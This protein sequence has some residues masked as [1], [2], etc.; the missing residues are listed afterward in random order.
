MPPHDRTTDEHGFGRVYAAH[1]EAVYGFLARRVGAQMA[2]ELTAQTFAEALDHLDRF[3]EGR[4]TH[5]AWLF[6]IAANLLRRHYRHEERSLRAIAAAA[7]S[8][9]PPPDLDEDAAIGRVVADE[10]WPE[11]AAA[12]LDMAPGERD[13]L[14][15]QA[16]A[17]LSYAEIATV[18]DIPIGTVRSRLSRARSRLT[19]ILEPTPDEPDEP[20][21]QR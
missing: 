14:L 18:L 3:D 8:P 16:W 17:D 5:A 9:P 19:A 10:R 11:V 1:V 7:T 12:L 20:D 15:L 21:D 13:A 4:G 6:G 2:E